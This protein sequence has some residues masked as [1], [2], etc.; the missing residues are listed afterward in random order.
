VRRRDFISLL[1]GAAAAA[2]P[3]AAR[4]QQTAMPVIGF[5]DAGSAAARTQQVAAFRKGLAE[6]GYQEGQNVSLEF[7]WAEGQYARFGELAAD[8]VRHRV[9]VI[10]TPGSAI[11]ALAAKAASTSIP[12]V[13]GVGGDPVR[14]GLVASLNRPGGNATGVNF[15]TVEVVAKR[16]QL[17][18][19]LVPAAKRIAVLVNPADPEGYQ[20]LRDVQAAAGGEQI[21]AREAA[22]GRDIDAA[23]ANMA[24][25]K[26]DAVFVGP[27]TF[28]NTRRVQL[29]VLTARYALPAAY[30]TRAYPE[31]GGLMSYGADVLDAFRQVGVYTGRI[32]KGAKPADLPV[33]QSTKFELVINLNTARALGLDVP[34]SLLA[35]ADEVIE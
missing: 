25:E 31:A 7:R 3:L 34:P 23:F 17:L 1:G 20:T 16:M 6:A 29:T 28:F 5:L 10:V 15:F 26:M 13:F 22:S 30:P 33:L 24:G 8:L 21:V 9:S 19:E 27:G 18:R 12:I 32:L 35:R 2:W 11:A 4:T 14:E